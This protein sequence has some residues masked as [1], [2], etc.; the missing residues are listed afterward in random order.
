MCNSQDVKHCVKS[1]RIRSFSD[2]YFA[3]F[4]LNMERYGVSLRIQSKC[5][6]IWTRKTPN[7]DTF[8]AVIYI[9]IYIYI[10]IHYVK[11]KNKSFCKHC[12]YE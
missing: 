12:I 4:G 7:T 2:P 10:Y 8:H 3:S 5:V 11:L 9:Y 6:K 1:V